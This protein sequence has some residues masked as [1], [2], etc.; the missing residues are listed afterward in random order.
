MVTRARLVCGILP[1]STTATRLALMGWVVHGRVATQY[2]G[3]RLDSCPDRV[4]R[5]M[6]RRSGL[7]RS[8]PLPG[9]HVRRTVGRSPLGLHLLSIQICEGRR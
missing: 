1:Q 5:L 7:P 8:P 6:P 4:K 9:S 2:H 3:R